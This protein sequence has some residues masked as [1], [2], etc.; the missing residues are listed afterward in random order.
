[1]ADTEKC[2]EKSGQNTAALHILIAV[3]DVLSDFCLGDFFNRG[4]VRSFVLYASGNFLRQRK[5]TASF[6]KSGERIL[7]DVWRKER[8]F[9][10]Y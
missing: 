2:S 6:G 9:L 7:P 4:G 5:K 1:M 10:E 8:Q 3:F